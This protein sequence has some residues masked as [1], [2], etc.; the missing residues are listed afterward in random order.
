MAG[1]ARPEESDAAAPTGDR[2]RGRG[3]HRGRIPNS[4]PVDPRR[5]RPTLK[6]CEFEGFFSRKNGKK[7]I[8]A[9]IH[10]AGSYCTNHILSPSPAPTSP[11]PPR[12]QGFVQHRRGVSTEML[13][14]LVLNQWCVHNAQKRESDGGSQNGQMRVCAVEIWHWHV[15]LRA[16]LYT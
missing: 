10:R 9:N 7:K 16:K 12:N 11:A 13:S 8:G 4:Q 2:D 15:R 1:P 3:G 6:L 14:L 5:R